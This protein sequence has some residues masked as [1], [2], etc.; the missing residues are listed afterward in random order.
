[1]KLLKFD[2]SKAKAS[3]LFV[4]SRL[5]EPGGKHA[6]LYKLLKCIYFA[7]KKHLAQYGR[8]LYGDFY[9][10]MEHGPVP[11]KTYDMVKA[12]RGDSF[13]RADAAK[14]G[15]SQA[16]RVEDN[17]IIPLHDPDM[18]ELS[19]SDIECLQ[20]A[21]RKLAPLSFGEI[22]GLS[23]DDAFNSAT[24]RQEE[25]MDFEDIARAGGADEEM[26][27]YVK[28]QIENASLFV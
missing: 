10:P 27:D 5:S 15:L 2:P 25:I 14:W 26:I 9:V 19:P 1:M 17:D 7:D 16:F 3:I 28:L 21:I 22:K 20:E 8:S 24:D 18:D 12:V 13:C 4:A 11:S 23:H 6:D